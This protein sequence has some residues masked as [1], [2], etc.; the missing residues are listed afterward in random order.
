[1]GSL[2]EA[3][4]RCTVYQSRGERHVL[5][6]E[7]L[8]NETADYEPVR[9]LMSRE[10]VCAK[11]DL[12]VAEVV[13]LMV[14][15]RI[16]CIPVVDDR[17]RPIGVVT[18][19]DV[20]ERLDTVMQETGNAKAPDL[21]VRTADEIMTPLALTLEE[22]DSILHAGEM[23]MSEETHHVLV[24]SGEGELVGVISCKDIVNWLVEHRDPS[25]ERPA[26]R[27]SS[28]QWHPLEG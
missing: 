5:A 20:V 6:R 24:V 26:E 2:N 16:G 27:I 8:V 3:S 4:R 15:H 13:H 11:P 7:N 21:A 12:D 9:T 25:A 19:F 10:L 1:M 22:D 14:K 23:M 18:K 28:P 17:R